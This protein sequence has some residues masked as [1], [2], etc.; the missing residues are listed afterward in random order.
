VIIPAVDGGKW[1][2]FNFSTPPQVDLHGQYAIVV[3]IH[4]PWGLEWLGS[5]STS[6]YKFGQAAVKGPSD[7]Y[8]LTIAQWNTVHH[9]SVCMGD[10]S[11]RTYVGA[12]VIPTHLQTPTTTHTPT[13][14]PLHTPTHTPAPTGA[15]TTT[16]PGAI[17]PPPPPPPSG[18]G[19]TD[20]AATP[21]ADPASVTS[22]LIT[23]AT[24][25]EPPIGAVAGSTAATLPGSRDPSSP[26]DGSSSGVPLAGLLA[27]IAGTGVAGAA[28]LLWRFKLRS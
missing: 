27:A 14:T 5:C 12:A 28:L 19:A 24:P 3:T 6:A 18:S 16:A 26:S 2:Y 25:L 4:G 23:E 17:P 1:V 7:P 11:F 8:W 21:T 10:F 9:T 20:P 15:H 22:P 13:P